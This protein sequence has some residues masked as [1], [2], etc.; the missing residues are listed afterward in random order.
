M[1]AA[2]RVSV[3]AIGTTVS[4]MDRAVAFYTGLLGFAVAEDGMLNPEA[5]AMLGLPDA[6]FRRVRLRL[7]A[8]FLDLYQALTGKGRPIPADSRS[9]DLWFQHVALVVSDMAAAYA[10]LRRAG[11]EAVSPGPQRLPDWNPGA[12]GITAFYFRDPDGRNLELIHFPPGKG[13]PRWQDAGGLLFLG[14]DHTALVVSDTGRA[15][16]F[17]RDRL[18]L[19]VAGEGLNH[20]TEQERLN[21]VPGVRL[22]ITLLKGESGPGVE[23]L[24]Y[25]NPRDGRPMPPDSRADD[26]WHW[27][28]GVSRQTL[29][30][31]GT[32]I[33]DPDGHAVIVA[34]PTE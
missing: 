11:V 12:A 23:L 30:R 10:A 32:L 2:R 6:G 17:Y 33:R 21:N 20:G 34:P 4:D 19:H 22:R 13:E 1:S 5:V 28:I 31:P 27:H 18:G 26:L 24:E 7:G 16:D 3:H 25:L 29:S 15:V 9:N 14:I 8:E